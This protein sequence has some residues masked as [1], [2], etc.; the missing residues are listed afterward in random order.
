[1]RH[2]LRHNQW[3]LNSPMWI[4]LW[5]LFGLVACGKGSAR[6]VCGDD[7]ARP[8]WWT[9]ASH[10]KG[11]PADYDEVFDATKVRRLDFKIDPA[12]FVAGQADLDSI[13]SSAGTDDLD[14][15]TKPMWMNA[16]LTYNSQT[17]TQVGVRW[18]GHASLAGAWSNKIGKLSMRVKFDEFEDSD[19]TLK[20][21]RFFGFKTFALSNSY[22]DDSFIRD[23]TAADVFRAAGVP[24]P[25][26]SFTQVYID[27]G[28]GPFYMGIYTIIEIPE[29]HMLDSQV[30]GDNGNLY[31]PWGDAAR[32]PAIAVTAVPLSTTSEDDIKTHFE[33]KTNKTDTGWTDIIAAINALH[34]DRT[35][36]AT[37]RANLESVFNVQSFLKYMAVNQTM[38]NWDAY[39]CMPHNYLI[40]ANPADSGRFLWLPWDLNEAFAMRTHDGCVPSSVMMDEIVSHSTSIAK[41]WPLIEY[42]LG[43][44]TYRTTYKTYLRSTLDGAF[45]A[46]AL[47][48]QMQADHDLIAPYLDGTI[49]AENG[50]VKNSLFTGWY[51]YQNATVADFKTSLT[52]P[53][54]GTSAD[55]LQVHVDNRHVAVEAALAAS[56]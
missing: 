25:R 10:C 31:K 16:T 22:K 12:V 55:G 15:I 37:W 24:A 48:A 7:V 42:I 38:V 26:G 52:R 41:E 20:N 11:A 27:I 34:A 2:D 29:D 28:N 3:F 53:A 49:A 6:S 4:L 50:A 46:A 14:A 8:D 35:N 21:Q 45:S 40:Y 17:W 36:A 43:D 51:T 23:K 19:P 32:W 30:G 18:K 1:M 9:Y 47:K 33:K 39:G 13:V 5:S 54:N 56:Q 44:T